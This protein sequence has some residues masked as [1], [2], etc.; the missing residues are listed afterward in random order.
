MNNSDILTQN[1]GRIKIR[2]IIV[3]NV[4]NSIGSSTIT[5]FDAHQHPSNI[6][7]Y[8]NSPRLAFLENGPINDVFVNIDNNFVD[9]ITWLDLNIPLYKVEI[10]FN[11][12]SKEWRKNKTYHGG[13]NFTYCCPYLHTGTGKRC[14][15]IKCTS[16]KHRY[17]CPK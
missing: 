4:S 13:G 10:D 14:G 16:L 17:L 7:T 15:K 1:T 11:N 6:I 8:G 2:K 12:S 9:G 3:K 5:I